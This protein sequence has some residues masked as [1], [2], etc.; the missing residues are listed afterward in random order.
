MS[1]TKRGSNTTPTLELADQLQQ[2]FDFFNARLFKGELEQC[3]LSYEPHK[4]VKG[5]FLPKRF[6]K[7]M[8]KRAS[9]DIVLHKIALNPMT[10]HERT[11]KMTLSTL[12]HEMVH[13]KVEQSGK[14]PVRPYHCKKWAEAM[15]AIGLIPVVV[16]SKGLPTGK[17]TGANATHEI[18]VGGPFEEACDEL[19]KSGFDLPISQLPELPKETKPKK[20]KKKDTVT[21]CCPSCDTKFQAKRGLNANCGDCDDHFEPQKEEEDDPTED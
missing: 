7:K 11:T 3:L 1:L 8:E 2:A 18:E 6:V 19:I 17:A 5:Y 16:N 21:Y 13:L 20:K 14:G 15:T 9:G 4:K 12:V 10:H